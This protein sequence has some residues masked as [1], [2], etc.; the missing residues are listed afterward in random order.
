[1]E[2]KIFIETEIR[3]VVAWGKGM[4]WEGFVT[5]MGSHVANI[6]PNNV[7]ENDI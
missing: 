7:S 5:V 4:E 1:M 6:S 3:S 2:C